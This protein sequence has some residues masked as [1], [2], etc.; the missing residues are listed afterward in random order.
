M[1][2]SCSFA[3]FKPLDVEYAE[4]CGDD[5]S[6]FRTLDFGEIHDAI[7]RET[8]RVAGTNKGISEKPITLRIHSPNVL[9]LTLIDLP[10]ITKVPVGDEP[11]DIEDKVKKMISNFIKR[12]NC[13]ILAVSPANV[14]LVNSE[15]VKLAKQ[16]DKKGLRTIGVLTKCDMMDQGTDARAIF[17][18]NIDWKLKLRRG[19]IG[20]VN[21]SQMDLH[22]KKSIESSLESEREFFEK[23]PK[24]RD[25]ASRLGTKHLQKMLNEQL[26]EH[27]RHTLPVEESK[28]RYELKAVEKEISDYDKLNPKDPSEVQRMIIE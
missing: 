7:I 24:Y 23:H 25:I 22:N 3:I 17:D 27:I 12:D 1:E 28:I 5:S 21:R 13:L 8:D 10:G 20:V 6:N 26:I 19:Y 16:F 2:S 15:A 18:G 14:D 4:L 11:P 9:D